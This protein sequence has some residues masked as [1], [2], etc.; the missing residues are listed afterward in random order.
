MLEWILD[1]A[2]GLMGTHPAFAT[3]LMIVGLFR[4]LF[5]PLIAMVD[6]YVNYTENKTDDKMFKDFLASPFYST[7][8]FILDYLA[9]IKLK[10]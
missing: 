10:K 1:F 5:K 6:A 9:S 7:I 8:V 4:V 3:V 2:V